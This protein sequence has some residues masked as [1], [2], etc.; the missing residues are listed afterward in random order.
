M[1]KI[2]IVT[3]SVRK[4]NLE[5]IDKC[6][7]RQSFKDWEWLV[8]SPEDYGYG[9][10][11]KDPPKKEG[12]FYGLNKCWN[13]MFRVVEGELIVSIQDGIWFAPD[14]LQK[15]WDHY[16]ADPKACIGAIGHQY[17]DVI[18][19]KP[20]NLV[21]QDP[22]A[23]T[24]QGSF[25]EVYYVDLEYSVCSIPKQAILDVGGL[26]TEWDK[27]AA[28]SEKEMN[29]RMVKAGYKM[30]LDQSQIYRAIH[31][32]R[33]S[34]DWDDKYRLGCAYFEECIRSIMRGEDLK[35]DL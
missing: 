6:L 4:E 1:I 8:G 9:T 14:M 32:E 20:E 2:S 15:F 27:Y 24:D 17:S 34:S 11:V 28:L 10:W 29:A 19:G 25:H 33:L 31:H 16:V 21:W 18:N 13:E 30:Y 35:G 3:P 23:R 12:D 7:K 26:K 22:R 5:I